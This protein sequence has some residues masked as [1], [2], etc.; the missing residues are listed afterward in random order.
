MARKY[1]K[2]G[3]PARHVVA[4]RNIAIDLSW[5]YLVKCMEDKNMEKKYKIDIAKAI[6]VKSIPT[7]VESNSTIY[8]QVIDEL[9]NSNPSTIRGIIEMLREGSSKDRSILAN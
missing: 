1:N 4:L 6:A 9:T 2:V 5:E 7:E 8:L 3:R